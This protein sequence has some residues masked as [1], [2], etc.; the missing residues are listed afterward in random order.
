[1]TAQIVEIAGHKMALL[2]GEEYVR[3]LDSVVDQADILAAVDAARR[4]A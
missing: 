1:M 3:P 2:P 4:R